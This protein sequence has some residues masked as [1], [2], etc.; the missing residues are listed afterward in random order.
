M[1]NKVLNVKALKDYVNSKDK[2]ISEGFPKALN[3][4]ILLLIGKSIARAENNG[5][6]TL[7]SYDK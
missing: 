2:R 3:E 7:M 6:K 5:R 1:E 4:E